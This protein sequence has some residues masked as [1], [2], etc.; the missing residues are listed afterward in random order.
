M[1]T[2]NTQKDNKAV[3]SVGIWTDFVLIKNEFLTF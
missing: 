2:E 1:N 3:P